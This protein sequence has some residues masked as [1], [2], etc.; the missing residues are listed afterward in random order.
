PPG[1]RLS[2]PRSAPGS[3]SALIAT[4]TSA[5]VEPSPARFGTRI[6]S[7][8][9]TGWCSSIPGLKVRS[10]AFRR[11]HRLKR[12][13]ELLSHCLCVFAA[14]L[15]D[16]TLVD[17]FTANLKTLPGATADPT[18][19]NWW[20]QH[21]EKWVAARADLQDPE[22]AMRRY[23]DWVGK[24]PGRPVFVAYPAGFDFLF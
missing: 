2:M 20:Q 3:G 8:P 5:T 9:N 7:G 23:V 17:T 21:P 18:T 14:F 12:A 6:L 11:C 22:L 10:P 13:Y 19:M 1:T 16:K 15:P 24:L 4:F